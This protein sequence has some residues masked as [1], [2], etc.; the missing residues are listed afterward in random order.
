MSTTQNTPGRGQ[1]GLRKQLAAVAAVMATGLVMAACTP[2]PD[3]TPTSTTIPS[4]A[5]SITVSNT[6]ALAATGSTVTV[7]GQG[8]DPAIVDGANGTVGVYVALGRGASTTVPEVYTAA[9]FVRPNGPSPETTSGAKMNPDGTFS[10]TI[11]TSALFSASGSAVNCYLESCSIYVFSAHTGSYAPWTFAKTPVTFKAPTSPM[12]AVSKTTG[13]NPAGQDVTI[14]GAGFATT[15]PGIYVVFGPVDTATPWWL[16]ASAFG[17]AKYLPNSTIGAG[18][19]FT[20]TLKPVASYTGSSPIDCGS[21]SCAIAT[22]KAHGSSD[23]TQDT[24]TAVTF[25]G[26]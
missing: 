7:T 13:L 4:P 9:K 24:V 20:T 17:D 15:A 8:F 19:T 25:A 5:P 16:D 11:S 22:M 12:V 26:A 21:T 6:T 23:R 3:T 10:A 18:G 2:P 1:R 14:T